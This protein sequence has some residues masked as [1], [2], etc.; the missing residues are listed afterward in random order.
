MMFGWIARL[1]CK[2]RCCP[3]DSKS[4]REHFLLAPTRE[5][6]KRIAITL[7]SDDRQKRRCGACSRP[8]AITHLVII[9]ASG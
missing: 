1:N 2:Q 8:I 4:G 5:D 6:A 3:H 9:E 7:L